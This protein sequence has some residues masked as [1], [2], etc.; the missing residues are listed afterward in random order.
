MRAAWAVRLVFAVLAAAGLVVS[1]AGPASAHNTVISTSPTTKAI[2]ARVPAKVV[3]TFNEP[4]LAMGTEIVVTGPNGQVQLGSPD[5]VDN[6]VTEAIEGEAPRGDYQ[7]V[8]RITSADG[9]P[10]SG[11]FTFTARAAGAGHRPTSPRTPVPV[12]VPAQ[13]ELGIWAL[14]VVAVVIVG[15][16]ISYGG[17]RR[18][19]DHGS[20]STGEDS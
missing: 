18:A 5:L 2:V 8:W 12:P 4:A 14:L 7:V 6:T 10:V 9:H 15:T 3:L 13:H 17:R 16:A 1:N 20:T 19:S 11:S